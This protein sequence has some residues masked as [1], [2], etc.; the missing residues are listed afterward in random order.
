M[1][2]NGKEIKRIAVFTSGGDAPGMNAALRAVVRTAAY[3]DLHV[4]GIL[5]GYEG[6]IDGDFILME[7]RDV[8]NIMHRGGTML[9]TARSERFMTPEGRKSAYESLRAYDIDACIAIG[10]NGTFTGATVFTEEYGVPF[11]GIPGTIDNDL[12]GTDYTIG[13]DTAVN[14][15]IQAADKIRDTAESHNRL[16][17]IEVMGRNSGL[18]ALNTAIGAGAGYAL[19]PEKETTIEELVDMLRIAAKRKKLFNLIVVAEGNKTGGAQ[20]VAE[21]VRKRLDLFDIRVTV[22]GHMQ[23]GG[24]PT[25]HDRVLASRL[26]QA[27]VEGL[28]EGKR[29][30]MVGYV[31]NKIKF[32]PL[33]DAIS[34]VKPPNEQLLRIAEML[35]I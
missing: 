21:E 25:F 4:Y 14:T 7:K 24:A 20:Q 28:L 13:F 9:K 17:F 1:K 11:I 3:Y 29:N 18:I 19:I 12:Y 16:F 34:K 27:A 8:G 31:D 23:R 35:A 26:G 6:M 5:R 33:K 22:I 10:G 30:V 2:S 15:A 32:T